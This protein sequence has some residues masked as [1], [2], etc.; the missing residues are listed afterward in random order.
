MHLIAKNM[1]AFSHMQK[2]LSHMLRK[3]E[4]ENELFAHFHPPEGKRG[5][6]CG[7]GGGSAP[8]KVRDMSV[9]PQLILESHRLILTK[10]RIIEG[11]IARALEQARDEYEK[12]KSVKKSGIS[13]SNDS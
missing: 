4:F 2:E 7:C 6:T 12:D 9:F 13:A 8:P 5:F 3:K 1:K 10:Q 11:W